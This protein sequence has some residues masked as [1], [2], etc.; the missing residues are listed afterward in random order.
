MHRFDSVLRLSFDTYE[1]AR[2]YWRDNDDMAAQIWLWHETLG[3]REEPLALPGVCDLCACQTT[4]TA[5]PRPM[6]PGDQFAFRVEWLETLCGCGRNTLDRSVYRVLVDGGSRDDRIYHVGHHSNFRQWLSDTLP[7][8]TSSQ[9]EDGRRPGEIEN[10]VRY[11]DLT[12]LS[13][14]DREFE[15]VICMEVLEHIP[16]YQAGLREIVRVLQSGGRAL[17]TFPWMGGE[18]YEHFVRAEALPDGSIRHIHP[19]EYHG[20][21][22]TSEPILSFRNFGWKILDDLRDAGFARASA[23]YVFGPLHGYFSFVTPIFVATR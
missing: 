17:F 9:Y 12:R 1:E 14:A 2:A 7:N 5:M 10:G 3:D 20:D 11:E 16:D 4:F 21:P 15:C 8:V 19:P 22:A 18:H 23:K 13:F 6:P